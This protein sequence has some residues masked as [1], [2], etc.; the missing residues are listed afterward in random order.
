MVP[1]VVFSAILIVASRSDDAAAAEAVPPAAQPAAQTA[2]Q[3]AAQ[4][5]AQSAP[6]AASGASPPGDVSE[7][8]IERPTERPAERPVE[9]PPERLVRHT[10]KLFG[11]PVEVMAWVGSADPEVTGKVAAAFD[12]I[13]RV[14]ALVDEDNPRSSVFRINAAAGR[15]PLVVDPELFSI[16]SEVVRLGKVTKGAF[17][18]TAAPFSAAWRFEGAVRDDGATPDASTGKSPLP[19]KSDIDRARAVVG[20]DDLVLD[21]AGRTVRLAQPGARIA[22]R[23]V[24]RGYALERAAAVLEEQELRHF[25]ISAGGDLVVRG[26]KGGRPWIV[27]L[28]DPRAAGYFAAL[29]A[30]AGAVM[31]T[32]D[33]EEFFFDGGVRYH[34]VLDPRT[35][36]PASA[37]RAVTVLA[38]DALSAEAVSRAVFVLGAKEGVALAERL[39]ADAVVVTGDNKVVVSRGLKDVAQVRPP[40][41]GP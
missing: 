39:K 10:R 25:V 16:L 23:S 36:L 11:T 24:A 2:A 27:G 40:T 9:L 37:C 34:N 14:E 28:Q 29:P 35:G 7:R 17:D 33:Y 18:V 13:R 41:D 12:E 32:G 31:T 21:A 3:P 1:L 8:P 5:A 26:K 38:R 30:S 6:A 15:E 4:P 20:I 22:L 19:T